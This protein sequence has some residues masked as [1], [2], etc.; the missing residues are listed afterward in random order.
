MFSTSITT[1][2]YFS[3]WTP[4]S[5]VTYTGS[6]VFLVLLAILFR[7]LIA[8][9]LLSKRRRRNTKVNKLRLVEMGKADPAEA[10]C[11]RCGM[12]EKFLEDEW[13]RGG[14]ISCRT[15]SAT[16]EHEAMDDF[17]GRAQSGREHF[18]SRN[19]LLAVMQTPSLLVWV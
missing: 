19:F 10:S 6:C 13:N 12:C 7:F 4:T 5:I 16:E 1:A 9:T 17:C 15:T 8:L 11:Q 3:T 2:L 18:G 14:T